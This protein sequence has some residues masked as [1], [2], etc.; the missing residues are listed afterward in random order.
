MILNFYL[1][2]TKPRRAKPSKPREAAHQ[3]QCKRV[4]E[5]LIKRYGRNSTLEY[6]ND[7]FLLAKLIADEIR[8]GSQ[9]AREG[10]TTTPRITK[11]GRYTDV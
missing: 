2:E 3:T 4:K 8:K 6:P 1:S 11:Q 10:L 9:P 7:V 5:I